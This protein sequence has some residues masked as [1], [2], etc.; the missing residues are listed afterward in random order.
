MSRASVLNWLISYSLGRGLS[1]KESS[2]QFKRDQVPI[3]TP[4]DPA[5]K[6]MDRLPGE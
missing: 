2:M 5:G 3:Y 1:Q 4:L 6:Q